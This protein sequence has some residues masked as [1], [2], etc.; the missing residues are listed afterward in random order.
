MLRIGWAALSA[1]VWGYAVFRSP[2]DAN[3]QKPASCESPH[4]KDSGAAIGPVTVCGKNN[5]V[6]EEAAQIALQPAAT[7]VANLIC[8]P[9]STQACPFCVAG[10]EQLAITCTNLETPCSGGTLF[11]CTA[12]VTKV[13]CRCGT[14]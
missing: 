6:A 4:W 3:A 11:S 8:N 5:H 12:V 9:L 10:R 13:N 1:A 2:K 7:A 14:S